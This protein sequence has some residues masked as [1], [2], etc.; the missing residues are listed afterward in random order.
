MFTIFMVIPANLTLLD[1][2][3]ALIIFPQAVNHTCHAASSAQD[4]EIVWLKLL[5][6]C[7]SVSVCMLKEWIYLLWPLTSWATP[8][9]S[10]TRVSK[11][12]WCF[13][14][15]RVT[16]RTYSFTPMIPMPS[17]HC[18]VG[19]SLQEAFDT[20]CVWLWHFCS[21]FCVPVYL[22][23][24]LAVSYYLPTYLHT[25]L[26][27]CLPTYLSIYLHIYLPTGLYICLHTRAIN[28]LGGP[29]WRAYYHFRVVYN[30]GNI[31]I[32]VC[33]AVASIISNDLFI[34]KNNVA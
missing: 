33:S 23:V 32:L 2:V 3:K 16:N 10:I 31:I 30:D 1:A 25:C 26:P 8:S 18:T 20:R 7:F 4:F 6:N 15:T 27:T 12:R 24:Y 21:T 11:G 9:V 19:L 22:P 34:D 28:Y 5:I 17:K 29:T 13:R 14:G